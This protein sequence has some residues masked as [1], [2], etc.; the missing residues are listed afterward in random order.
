MKQVSWVQWL[1]TV[2]P[3]L[4]E[5]E[6]S[7]SRGQEF[8]TS[9]AKMAKP[10]LYQRYKKLAGHAPGRQDE[11]GKTRGSHTHD[12]T[13]A[14]TIIVIVIIV[15]P[16]RRQGF[17]PS[18]RLESDGMSIAHCSLEL[19]G[20][21]ISTCLILPTG[22][23]GM[24]YHIWL[25]FV[26]EKGCGSHYVAQA[27]LKLLVLSYPPALASQCAGITGGSHHT[28]TVSILKK[29]KSCFLEPFDLFVVPPLSG[30]AGLADSLCRITRAD[31]A[32][33]MPDA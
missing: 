8:E 28:H 1:M 26:V 24:C 7:R 6:A 4:W 25:F 15:I 29:R 10:S 18:P 22:T 20:S 27:C 19:L 12:I 33:W 21:S 32:H 30:T 11:C 31:E 17:I 13:S 16:C 9:L 2:I 14:T 3:S 23:I 5:A